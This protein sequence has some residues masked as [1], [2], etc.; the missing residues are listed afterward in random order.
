MPITLSTIP[1]ALQEVST[2]AFFTMTLSVSQKGLHA[3]PLEVLY[4]EALEGLRAAPLKELWFSPCSLY[5][6][7]MQFV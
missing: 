3:V 1:L 6:G 7:D 5:R 2:T 4:T